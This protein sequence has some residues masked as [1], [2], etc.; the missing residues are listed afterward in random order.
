MKK[1]ILLTGVLVLTITNLFYSNSNIDSHQ[2][3]ILENI[4]AL[5][6]SA[7]EAYCDGST[8]SECEFFGIGKAT[9]KLIF[10]Y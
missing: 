5:G 4:D 10:E 7:G 3:L 2:D 6:V 1:V 8:T 9:G